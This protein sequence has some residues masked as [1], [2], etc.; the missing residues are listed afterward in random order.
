MCAQNKRDFFLK[1]SQIYWFCVQ[2]K[3][4]IILIPNEQKKCDIK[5]CIYFVPISESFDFSFTMNNKIMEYR[6]KGV[7][8]LINAPLN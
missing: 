7:F 6:N 1:A 5:K 2:Y 4:I 3:G 8:L